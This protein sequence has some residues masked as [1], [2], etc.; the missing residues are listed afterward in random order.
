ML[1]ISK[2]FMTQN[3]ATMVGL[4]I[5]VGVFSLAIGIA[6]LLQNEQNGVAVW[7]FS[8]LKR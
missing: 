4:L 8:Y 2:K 1:K 7:P 3:F 6:L 5:V